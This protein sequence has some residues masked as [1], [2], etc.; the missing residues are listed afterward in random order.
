MIVDIWLREVVQ[1]KTWKCLFTKQSLSF[2]SQIKNYKWNLSV[3][4]C[5]S[6]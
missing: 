1:Y 6:K 2:K 3:A 4:A 5:Y